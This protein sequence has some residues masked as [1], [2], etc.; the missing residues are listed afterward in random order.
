MKG[1]MPPERIEERGGLRGDVVRIVGGREG[2]W[3]A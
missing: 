1:V 3:K 2:E